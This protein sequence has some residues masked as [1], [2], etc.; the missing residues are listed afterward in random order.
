MLESGTELVRIF[1]PSS[2]GATATSFRF[3]GPL[4][5]FDHHS[6]SEASGSSAGPQHT[7]TLDPNRGVYYAARTLSSCVVELFGDDRLVEPGG[8]QVALP[9]VHRDLTLL[10]LRGS[11]AMRAGTVA[12]VSKAR[13]RALTQMW[14]RHFHEAT[15]V[16][17]EVDGLIYAGAHNDADAICL[18]ER[19]VEC[20][21]CTV[22]CVIGLD[23]P[24]LRPTILEAAADNDL[25]VP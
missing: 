23:D 24:L 12:A 19:A 20:L 13:D 15:D 21:E 5:R 6:A 22:D 10:D 7:P 3:Y 17:G 25:W 16:Y 4:H 2:H 11:G 14:S 9:V 8:L 1:D 18:Y